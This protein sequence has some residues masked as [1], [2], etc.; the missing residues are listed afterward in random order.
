MEEHIAAVI[1]YLNDHQN[2]LLEYTRHLIAIPSMNPPGDEQA[3]ADAVI[4]RLDAMGF[5]GAV[6]K[7]SL[8]GRMYFC[9]WTVIRTGPRSC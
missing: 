4:R 8:N 6:V 3:M 1:R 2:E 5:T 7:A 9:G